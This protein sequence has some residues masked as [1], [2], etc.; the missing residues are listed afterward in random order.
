ME[1]ILSAFTTS[2][3]ATIF[4]FGF[5]VRCECICVDYCQLF[6]ARIQTGDLSFTIC[7]SPP[8]PFFDSVC[9]LSCLFLFKHEFIRIIRWFCGDGAL[10]ALH[11]CDNS[12]ILM[13]LTVNAKG[14]SVTLS[15]VC[16]CF[17]RYFYLV[18]ASVFVL[19]CIRNRR[20]FA[21]Q[22]F[23]IPAFE[24]CPKKKRQHEAKCRTK[25]TETKTFLP[26]TERHKHYVDL[27]SI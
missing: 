21:W 18:L 4:F 26:K 10:C 22:H 25:S 12:I 24:K 27:F 2:S 6:S 20:F 8:P 1:N 16:M 7:F 15:V 19:D 3:A 11:G 23:S 5:G 14:L 17:F 13:S 9:A